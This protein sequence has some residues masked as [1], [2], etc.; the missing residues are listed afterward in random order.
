MRRRL[1]ALALVPLCAGAGEFPRALEA[2]PG[3]AP[4]IDGRITEGEWEGAARFEGPAGWISQFSPVRD[5]KDLSFAGWVKHDGK[6]LYFAFRVSDDVLYGL[7]TPRWLPPE[8]A[9]AHELTREG[10]PWFGDEIEL[11]I[12]AGGGWKGTEGAAGDGS[13]W[14]M[15]CNLTKSRLGGVGRG[16]LLEGEPRS[17]ERAWNTYRRW[18]ETGAMEAAAQP[19]EG[20]HGYEVEW[21]VS[22]DPCLEVEPGRY[23]SVA[24]GDRAFG[25]N[26]AV[27]DL[28][29][30]GKGRGNFGNFHHEE[31]W[32]GAKDVRTQLRNFGTLWIRT[33]A[34]GR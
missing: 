21:A 5:P 26:M 8:N 22:F 7:D 2:W 20:G 11:L 32:A 10:W 3:G 1:A 28:D 6:R 30:P 4:A 14:Q 12:Q 24:M 13:S 15:V 27:G 18:I 25:L 31:W 17:S 9:K 23:Y 16:G 29:E 19:M 33:K 34:R